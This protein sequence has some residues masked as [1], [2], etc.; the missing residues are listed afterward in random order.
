MKNYSFILLLFIAFCT[1]VTAQEWE[2]VY[3]EHDG[4]RLVLKN[5]KYGYIDASGK[6]AVPVIYDDAF[7]FNEN[8][9]LVV[10]DGKRGFV[11]KKGEVVI[12]LKYDKAYSFKNGKATVVLGN[13]KG[14]ITPEGKVTW[15]LS[16]GDFAHGGVVIKLDK[17]GE[18]GVVCDIKDCGGQGKEMNYNYLSG[19]IVNLPKKKGYKSWRIP[20]WDELVLIYKHRHLINTTALANK[21]QEFGGQFYWSTKEQYDNI[22]YHY[23]IMLRGGEMLSKTVH[24]SKEHSLRAVRDF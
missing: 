19:C 9:G 23:I 20:R 13:K 21:G 5:K 8:L 6:V 17:T 2:K 15:G 12:P 18:H 1:Q 11:N 22:T 10:N 3:A 24:I 16:V 7:D 14:K 4:L